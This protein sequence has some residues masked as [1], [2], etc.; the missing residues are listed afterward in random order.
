MRI[1]QG[2]HFLNDRTG[3]RFVALERL[4][5]A[6]G[7]SILCCHRCGN[8]E[9]ESTPF[10]HCT[11]DPDA[12]PVSL[13]DAFGD[14][15]SEPGAQ[16]PGLGCLPEPVKDMGYVLGRDAG[17]RIRHSEDDL[18]IPRRRADREATVSFRELDRVADQVFEYLKES[19]PIAPDVGKI[20]VQVDS[21]IESRP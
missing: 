12:T 11:F 10:A 20:T 6:K 1:V 17:A 15:K 16:T 7:W 9:K 21:K 8:R 4:R 14:R 2:R 3:D 19:I 13:D 18:M 5:G